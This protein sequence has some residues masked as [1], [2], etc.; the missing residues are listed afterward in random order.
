MDKS[1][2]ITRTPHGIRPATPGRLN[3][4]AYVIRD[5]EETTRFY[6][7]ILG[8]PLVGFVID[9]K[10]PSTGDPFPYVHLFFELGDGSSLAFF[11]SVGLPEP[12]KASHPAYNVFNHL[13]L[14][15][16]TPANV[17]QWASHLRSHGVEVIG[18]VDHAVI[19]SVYF[20]DPNGIRLELTCN[21]LWK[22]DV[23]GS[24]ESLVEW[25]RAKARSKALG[26]DTAPLLEL[27]QARRALHKLPAEAQT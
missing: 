16:G 20:H 6:R 2:A 17:D 18:P 13:A 4:A 24:A 26:G 22:P 1:L 3:H 21:T 5:A 12:A 23:A 19:Y 27:I 25:T 10:V 15:V 11:E 14:D 9:D 7:D 8:L